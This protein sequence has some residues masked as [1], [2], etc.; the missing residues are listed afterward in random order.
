M[1]VDPYNDIRSLQRLYKIFFI[2]LHNYNHSGN[3]CESDKAE[4]R[5]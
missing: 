2:S 3:D 4:E 1:G 5:R